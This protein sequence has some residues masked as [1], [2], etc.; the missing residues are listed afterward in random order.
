MAYP[1]IKADIARIIGGQAPARIPFFTISQEFDACFANRTYAEYLASAETMFAAQARAVRAF[2]YDWVLYQVHDGLEFEPL[3]LEVSGCGNILPGIAS[4]RPISAAGPGAL[5]IPAFADQPKIRVVLDAIRQTR[6]EFGDDLIILGRIAAPLTAATLFHGIDATLMA[7]L[8]APQ[9]AIV[10]KTIDFFADLEWA[11]AQ[12]QFEYGADGVWL[13]DCLASSKLIS[14]DLHRQFAFA[15]NQR[16][17]KK[18]HQQGKLVFFEP[19]D[20]KPDFI[21]TYAAEGIDLVNIGIG[22]DMAAAKRELHGSVGLMGN[23]DSIRYLQNG[24]PEEVDREVER[25]V[26]LGKPGG[27]YAFNTDSVPRAAKPENMRAMAAAVRRCG[28]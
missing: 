18:I 23:L 12:T 4:H 7:L 25:I 1:G 19:A 6:R 16:L 22:L 26:R 2:D 20:D 17:V 24:T 28:K 10:R 13:G 15:P 11:F 21:R 8:D 5:R 9:A 3:G 14:L 27:G